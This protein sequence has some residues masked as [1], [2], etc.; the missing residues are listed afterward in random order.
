MSENEREDRNET[1]RERDDQPR[2][3]EVSALSE[4]TP[5]AS[6][7]APPA[8]EVV[9]QEESPPP[10]PSP[11]EIEEL[12]RKAEQVEILREQLLRARADYDNLQKRHARDR[13]AFR[14][15]ALEEFIRTL[16]PGLDDL[17]RAVKADTDD[18]A[19]LR[20]GVRMALE[21][22]HRALRQAGV[23]RVESEGKPF[24]PARHEA[25]AVEHSE[26]CSQPLVAE[27]IRPGY[28]LG[29][30]LIRHAQV[31]VVMPAGEPDRQQQTQPEKPA[32]GEND[33]DL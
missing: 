29:D 30:R 19:A 17:E 2:G 25:L 11:E 4:T 22:L 16:L 13:E 12:R 33:A 6:S 21:A 7:E 3:E 14:R 5:E 31:K 9:P 32:E 23:E 18:A 8:Q 24:D 27:E 28:L 15:H 20:Q 1:Q 26:N 10:V